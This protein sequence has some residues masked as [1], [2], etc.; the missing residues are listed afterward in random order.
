MTPF[1]YAIVRARDPNFAA[2]Y[3]N[4]G[5]L[6]L[7]PAAGK[8]WLRRG[9]LRQR[10]HLIGDDAA[11]TSALLDALDEEAA[12]VARE[13]SAAAAH[14][15]LR[16]KTRATEDSLVLADA[17]VGVA[18]DVAAEVARLRDRYLGPPSRSGRTKADGLRLAVLRAHGLHKAFEPRAFESGPATWRFPCVGAT[19]A[20]PVVFNAL[21]FGQTKPESLLDAAFNNIGR[22][23]EVR[24]WHGQVRWLTLATGPTGGETGP[25]FTRACELM[26][27]A[28]LNPVPADPDRIWAAL[29]TLGVGDGPSKIAEA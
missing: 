8:A 7:C 15:W 18:E 17:A 19:S 16:A 24:R 10:A 3:R 27:D 9:A 11:F 29:R 22:A 20:G 5:L 28:G 6:V 14:G 25:A 26:A 12:E 21:E 23:N 2:E 13:G 4:V 1:H